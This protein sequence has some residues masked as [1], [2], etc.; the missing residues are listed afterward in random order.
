[1]TAIASY[2]TAPTKTVDVHGTAFA[3][4]ELGPRTGTPVI[5]LNHPQ[6]SWTTGI[7]GLSTASPRGGG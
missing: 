2:R 1:M 5:F 7:R 3:Y 4:R 6:P